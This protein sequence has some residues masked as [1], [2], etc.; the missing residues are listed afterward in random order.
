[1][2]KINQSLRALAIDKLETVLLSDGI[3]FPRSNNGE[4]LAA[5]KGAALPSFERLELD[6]L[7]LNELSISLEL[8]TG[9]ELTTSEIF[10][11]GSLEDLVSVLT[12]RNL[13]SDASLSSSQPTRGMGLRNTL[14]EYSHSLFRELAGSHTAESLKKISL[15]P[16]G[17]LR[18]FSQISEVVDKLEG[19]GL[20]EVSWRRRHL[21]SDALLY[22]AKQRLSGSYPLVVFGGGFRRPGM[23]MSFF[24]KGI[25]RLTDT[26]VFLRTQTGDGFRS[27]IRGL[28][29]D[30]KQSFHRL[31]SL[32]YKILSPEGSFV[33]PLILG[34]SAGGLPALIFSA[35]VP[36][37]GVVLVGP[38]STDDPRWSQ[39]PDLHEVL[40]MRKI[41]KSS[42]VTIWY[43]EN[44]KDYLKIPSWTSEIANCSIVSIPQAD[45][46]AV[47][48]LYLRAEL[49]EMLRAS[50]KSS[51]EAKYSS[52]S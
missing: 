34:N 11:M 29:P 5:R 16:L 52:E 49:D 30:L 23:P 9:I 31:R 2:K 1:M 37:Q 39:S 46:A 7:G 50:I 10:E 27:G 22:K 13:G 42:L 15:L 3:S 35:Y 44:S 25:E 12:E 38:N 17:G 47:H 40:E 28:G 51:R 6:S 48:A 41:E 19:E 26:V 33:P 32:T 45:H 18:G 8:L 24:L 36:N 43:G 21:A 20:G 4:W 14:N